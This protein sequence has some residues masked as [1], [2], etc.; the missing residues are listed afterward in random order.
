MGGPPF[1]PEENLEQMARAGTWWISSGQQEVNRRTVYMIQSRSYPIPLIKV[2][3]GPNL[4]ESCV[5]RGNTT[6]TPQVFSLFNGKFPHRQSQAMAERI[7]SEVGPDPLKQVVRTFQLAFQRDPSPEEKTR[8]LAFPDGIR[9]GARARRAPLI[10][11]G[12]PGSE[13]RAGAHRAR[14]GRDRLA[15]GSLSHPHQHE[16]VCVPGIGSAG[17][18]WSTSS[19]NIGRKITRSNGHHAQGRV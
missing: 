4:D 5:V 15:C 12:L 11:T 6:V 18:R 13:W 7:R 8:S 16:R 19:S 17:S 14:P 2:F 3:D 9:R 1:F 10:E